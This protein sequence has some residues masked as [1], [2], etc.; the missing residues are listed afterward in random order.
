MFVIRCSAVSGT[1]T[2]PCAA[3]AAECL[4]QCAERQPIRRAAA[5][6]AQRPAPEIARRDEGL[7]RGSDKA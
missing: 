4:W 2:V 6:A 1:R 3:A 7:R 5:E